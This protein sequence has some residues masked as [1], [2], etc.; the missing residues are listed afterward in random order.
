M[1][2]RIQNCSGVVFGQVAIHRNIF[3]RAGNLCIQSRN[4]LTFKAARDLHELQALVQSAV[5]GAFAVKLQLCVLSCKLDLSI[6]TNPFSSFEQRLSYMP[7]VKVQ[8]RIMELCTSSVFRVVPDAEWR[9][10]CGIEVRSLYVT[11]THRGVVTVRVSFKDFEWLEK[12]RL[13]LL[14]EKVKELILFASI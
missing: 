11:V 1:A 2:M 5:S 7:F 3:H 8:P 9:Q 12:E 14:M 6:D 10:W 13:V 4:S